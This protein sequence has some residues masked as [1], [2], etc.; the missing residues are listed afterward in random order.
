MLR[1]QDL[2]RPFR[3]TAG[4]VAHGY[5]YISHNGKSVTEHRVVMQKV[6]GRPLRK[7]ENVHHKNG[8][9]LDNRPENLELWSKA[10]PQGQRVEDKLE[11]AREMLAEYEQAQIDAEAEAFADSVMRAAA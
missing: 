10:Q 11:W 8:N 3:G 9:K 2:D 5:R 4:F 7:H 6:L 1:G